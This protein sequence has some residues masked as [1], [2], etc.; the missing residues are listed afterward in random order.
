VKRKAFFIALCYLQN[1]IPP[2][3]WDDL[4]RVSSLVRVANRLKLE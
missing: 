1:K 2:R 4:G 3:E